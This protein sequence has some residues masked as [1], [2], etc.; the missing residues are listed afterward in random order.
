MKNFVNPVVFIGWIMMTLMS[1]SS[2][3]DSNSDQVIQSEELPAPAKA[4][5]SNYFPNTTYTRVR[6][7]CK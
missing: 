2:D 3:D 6:K 5:V 4:F 7:I 1:C